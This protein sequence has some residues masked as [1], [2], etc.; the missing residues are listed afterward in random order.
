[1]ILIPQFQDDSDHRRPSLLLKKVESAT[2]LI[3]MVMSMAFAR[4]NNDRVR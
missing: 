4:D 3:R 1:M 2:S